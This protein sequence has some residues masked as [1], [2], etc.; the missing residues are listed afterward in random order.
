MDKIQKRILARRE[1]ILKGFQVNWLN[2]R[3]A[4][5]GKVLWQ[6][7]SDISVSNLEIKAKVPKQIFE[8]R[9]VLT[10]INFSSVEPL[11]RFRTSNPTNHTLMDS[12]ITTVSSS[13]KIRPPSLFKPAPY[14]AQP[15]TNVSLYKLQDTFVYVL[16]RNSYST[17]ISVD[18]GIN[19]ILFSGI[20]NNEDNSKMLEKGEEIQKDIL[21][22]LSLDKKR[23][24]LAYFHRSLMELLPNETW[25][26]YSYRYLGVLKGGGD[27]SSTAST[28]SYVH[29]V[30]I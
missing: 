30:Y 26:R 16:L 24:I 15:K 21:E 12:I 3:D 28:S 2:I 18:S 9:A 25:E 5:T 4:D 29:V 11:E 8:C 1:D 27:L 13:D 23:Y 10:Q 20:K 19:T 14:L 7:Y 22:K 17:G 6:V